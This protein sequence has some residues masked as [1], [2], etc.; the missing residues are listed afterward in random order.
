MMEPTC[1]QHYFHCI[2]DCKSGG[3]HKYQLF[4]LNENIPVLF[5]AIE[6]FIDRILALKLR[7]DLFH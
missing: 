7:N 6:I 2:G 3:F 5:L 4:H 1:K